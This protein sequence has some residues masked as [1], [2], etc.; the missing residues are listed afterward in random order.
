MR[1]NRAIALNAIPRHALP[2]VPSFN[3]YKR[4]GNT[5]AASHGAPRRPAVLEHSC[6]YTMLDAVVCVL[7]L[8]DNLQDICRTHTMHSAE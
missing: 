4:I 5:T 6:C 7:A 3:Q 2:F 1:S 8:P